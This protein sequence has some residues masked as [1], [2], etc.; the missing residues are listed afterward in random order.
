M[1]R[2]NGETNGAGRNGHG[3][4]APGNLGGPGRPRRVTERD[5]LIVLTEECPPER[6]RLIC[7]RATADAEAGDRWAREWVARY[8]MGNPAELPALGAVTKDPED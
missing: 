7:R 5:Y 6:W 3:Q 4:F 2:L 1:N 8:L